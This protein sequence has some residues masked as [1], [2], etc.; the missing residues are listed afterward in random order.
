[1]RNFGLGGRSFAGTLLG[2]QAFLN[3]CKAQSKQLK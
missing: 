1:M 3:R 2:S